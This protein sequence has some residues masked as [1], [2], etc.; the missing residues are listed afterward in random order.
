[1]ISY[2]TRTTNNDQ[3]PSYVLIMASV[4]ES[5]WLFKVIWTKEEVVGVFFNS[6]RMAVTF[7]RIGIQSVITNKPNQ[8]NIV[9]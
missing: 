6:K 5:P 7:R 9:K 3:R 4:I 8:P 2:I 1:M